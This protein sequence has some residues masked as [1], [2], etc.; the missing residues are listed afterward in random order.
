[1]VIDFRA[2]NAKTK[3]Q[4]IVLVVISQRRRFH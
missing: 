2:E 1:M 4:R 3:L